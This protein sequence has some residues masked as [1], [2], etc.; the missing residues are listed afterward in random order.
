[1]AA[2]SFFILI[3]CLVATMITTMS[4]QPK[5]EIEDKEKPQPSK[6]DAATIEMLELLMQ[7]AEVIYKDLGE[8][9]GAMDM[10][11]TKSGWKSIMGFSG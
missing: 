9:I 10:Y 4:N 7:R 5:K 6:K 3:A 11:R 2:R 1:M 8:L